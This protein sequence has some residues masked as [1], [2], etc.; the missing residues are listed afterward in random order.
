[1]NELFWIIFGIACTL[2]V[3]LIVYLC[4]VYI[5]MRVNKKKIKNTLVQIRGQVE[6]K[7]D[8]LKEYVEINKDS[9]D[10]DQY[11]SYVNKLGSYNY[12]NEWNVDVLKEFNEYYNYHL[13]NFNDDLLIKQCDESELKIGYIKDYYNELVYGFNEY[14][15][16]GLNYFLA[17]A[18]SIEDEK[19]Y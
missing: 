19:L 12:N 15:S 16:N 14:K 7:H 13:R 18:M 17:K 11:E 10:V 5:K 9:M 3:L 2:V 1:M 8:L 6:I 4:Q